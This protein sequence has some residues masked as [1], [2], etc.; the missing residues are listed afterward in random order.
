[1]KS[2]SST[3]PVIFIFAI[4]LFWWVFSAS[5]ASAF[6]PTHA[7]RVELDDTHTAYAISYK[8][9]FMNRGVLVPALAH[10][11]SSTW[12]VSTK[13]PPL[14]YTLRAENGQPVLTGKTIDTIFSR[15]SS[16]D[17]MFALEE[18]EKGEYTLIVLHEH[19]ADDKVTHMTI[20]QLPFILIKDGIEGEVSTYPAKDMAEYTTK[21]QTKSSYIMY[22]L[23][24]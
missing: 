2:I 20:D 22:P 7:L 5:A 17:A 3:N 23:E 12:P 24:D 14:T 15:A 4:S 18:S 6:G 8:F 9:N 21:A 11:A 10:R 13:L 19:A 1:M 16:T